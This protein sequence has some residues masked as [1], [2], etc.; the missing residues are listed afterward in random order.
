MFSQVQI[1]PNSEKKTIMS[2]CH[3]YHLATIAIIIIATITSVSVHR[4]RISLFLPL[5]FIFFTVT[6]YSCLT[7]CTQ[8]RHTIFLCP[9]HRHSPNYTKT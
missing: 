3:N 7:H 9:T 8:I 4:V 5:F 2:T 1:I 6:L